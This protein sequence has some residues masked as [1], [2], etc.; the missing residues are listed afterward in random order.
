MSHFL[1]DPP[2]YSTDTFTYRWREWL[3]RVYIYIRETYKITTITSSTYTAGNEFVILCNDDVAG[4]AITVNLP[5]AI[6][7]SG[8][9]YHIKKLGT[10]GN[11][12]VDGNG[13]QTIDGATT[14]VLTT[15]YESIQIVSDGA[16]WSII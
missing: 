10:T 3:N 6:G 16:N 7:I 1:P 9:M 14:A 8:K 4:G 13:S 2:P 5:T 11:I 15:Q 12:T